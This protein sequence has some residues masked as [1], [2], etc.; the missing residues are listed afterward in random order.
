MFS[1]FFV[2]VFLCYLTAGTLKGNVIRKCLPEKSGQKRSYAQ[3]GVSEINRKKSEMRAHNSQAINWQSDKN[4]VTLVQ[5]RRSGDSQS[6]KLKCTTFNFVSSFLTA[7][8]QHEIAS[9][10]TGCRPRLSG[11]IPSW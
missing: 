2:F 5:I 9:G 11:R 1:V 7:A 3:R 8:L 10:S 6:Y 4:A